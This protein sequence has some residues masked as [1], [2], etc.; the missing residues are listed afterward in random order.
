MSYRETLIQL[1]RARG[2]ENYARSIEQMPSLIGV[3]GAISGISLS[4]LKSAKMMNVRSAVIGECGLVDPSVTVSD[5]KAMIVRRMPGE[6]NGSTYEFVRFSQREAPFLS[7]I[8]QD[9]D[10]EKIVFSMAGM[11]SL[12]IDAER[13]ESK[14]GDRSIVLMSTQSKE[15]THCV[16]SPATSTLTLWIHEVIR[17][18]EPNFPIDAIEVVLRPERHERFVETDDACG[19]LAQTDFSDGAMVTVASQSTLDAMNAARKGLR[20]VTAEAFRMNILLE[21]LPPNA[22]DLIA[23]MLIRPDDDQPIVLRFGRMCVRC[24]VPCVDPETGV[25]PDGEPL[26][27]LLKNRPPRPQEDKDKERKSATF[28]I[29][30][31]FDAEERGRSIGVDDVVEIAE[32][33]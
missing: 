6:V 27:W 12:E 20:Q 11:P 13:L 7:L 29:N 10:G 5:R 17:K 2:A 9:V 4:P 21:G 14:H 8:Q 33:K 16:H 32:E 18:F 19:T 31:V 1:S 24:P 3:R 23:S 25:R 28:G 15:L 26:A 22:E 30:C